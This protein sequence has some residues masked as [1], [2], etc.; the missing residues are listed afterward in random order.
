MRA[1]VIARPGGPEVLEEHD[2]PLPEPGIGQIRVRV[3]ASALNRA[4]LMQRQGSY[5]APPGAPADIPGME[6]AGEVDA[7]GAGTTLWKLGDRVMGIVGGGA[8]AE[9]LVT[10]EREALP[11]PAGLSWESAAAI[12]EAFLTAYDALFNRIHLRLGERVLV[13]AVAS[14]VGTAV[15]QLARVA[16]ATVIGTSRSADKLARARALG[17]E[18]AIDAKA[19]DWAAT[20]EAAIGQNAVHAVVDLV[21]GGY[22]RGNLRV[23][24]PLGRLVIVGLTGGRATELDMGMVLG[25]RLTIVGTVLRSRPIEEKITLAREFAARVI[26]FFETGRLV[27]VVERAF[28]FREIQAAHVLLESNSTFGKVVLRWE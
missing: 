28:S 18:H 22:L 26:H 5:P 11:V 17:L 10:H 23:L 19:G 15:L 3:H 21:G 7:L 1:I 14:G 2:R 4:D 20:V 27:P 6:Y 16:G 9:Y 12:P 8:H 24:A 25:K 13:H